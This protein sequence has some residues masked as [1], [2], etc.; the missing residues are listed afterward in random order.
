MKTRSDARKRSTHDRRYGAP[1]LDSGSKGCAARRSFQYACPF[2]AWM[3]SAAFAWVHARVTKL[4]AF[5]YDVVPNT[6]RVGWPTSPCGLHTRPRWPFHV[7]LK[8]QLRVCL[9]FFDLVGVRQTPA[10]TSFAARARHGSKLRQT[11]SRY[12]TTSPPSQASAC[13]PA[14]ISRSLAASSFNACCSALCAWMGASGF[15][16]IRAMT[17]SQVE[18]GSS[19]TTLGRS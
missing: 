8:V 17:L 9:Y 10:P 2:S 15:A 1:A 12:F 14:G 18:A 3:F 13:L 7:Q 19:C 11:T 16:A 4:R 6:M 5:P